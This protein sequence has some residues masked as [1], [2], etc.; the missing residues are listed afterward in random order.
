[1]EYSSFDLRALMG[2]ALNTAMQMRSMALSRMEAS[3]LATNGAIR[4]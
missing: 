3:A 4:A 2:S 1:M